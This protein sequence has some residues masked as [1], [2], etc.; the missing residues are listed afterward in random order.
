MLFIKIANYHFIAW[1]EFSTAYIWCKEINQTIEKSLNN[2]TIN[3]NKA[4]G[5]TISRLLKNL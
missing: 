1:Q 5:K 2:Y 3:F 4:V